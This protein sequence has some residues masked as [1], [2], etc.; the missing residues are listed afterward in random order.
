MA[1]PS[2]IELDKAVVHFRLMLDQIFLKQI[3]HY[4][5]LFFQ[6]RGTGK[7][8]TARKVHSYYTFMVQEN[9]PK[10]SSSEFQGAHGEVNLRQKS[11]NTWPNDALMLVKMLCKVFEY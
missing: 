8:S 7:L 3:F 10:G 6:N 4:I 2:F 1:W 9:D 11:I 5:T